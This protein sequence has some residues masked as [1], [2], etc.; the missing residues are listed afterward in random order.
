[1]STSAYPESRNRTSDLL[2]TYQ[3]SLVKLK[4]LR[5]LQRAA[6]AM[7]PSG[8]TTIDPLIGDQKVR[9]NSLKILCNLSP[10]RKMSEC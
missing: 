9:S 5:Y 10:V 4:H 7:L 6:T 1:M 3:K 2:I 8:I